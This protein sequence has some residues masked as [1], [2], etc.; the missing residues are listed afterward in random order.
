MDGA[1]AREDGGAW[2]V[3]HPGAGLALF[4]SG[5]LLAPTLLV[6]TKVL[7]ADGAALADTAVGHPALRCM[8]CA[9][10]SVVHARCSPLSSVVF[11]FPPGLENTA[12]K[13]GGILG[14]TVALLA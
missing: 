12:P 11:Y 14:D 6:D 1:L 13:R 3:L 4:S 7:A 8:L 10:P 2:L 5:S 9:V